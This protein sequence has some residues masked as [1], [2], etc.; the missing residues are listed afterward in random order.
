ML[1]DAHLPSTHS[2]TWICIIFKK[3][4]N[5]SV[6][7]LTL[8]TIILIGLCERGLM[9]VTNAQLLDVC[10]YSMIMYDTK[11]C[12]WPENDKW[13]AEKWPKGWLIQSLKLFSKSPPKTA[14]PVMHSE[15]SIKL[16]QWNVAYTVW[17]HSITVVISC[18]ILILF[19]SHFP[20]WHEFLWAHFPKAS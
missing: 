9:C 3:C 13:F 20:A 7:M 14:V 15:N 11:M 10:L 17:L 18:Q 5:M 12:L 1:V 6:K 19:I 2:L 8:S 16:E 4:R